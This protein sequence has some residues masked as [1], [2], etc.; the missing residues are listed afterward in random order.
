MFRK[1]EAEFESR[2]PSRANTRWYTMARAS[3]WICQQYHEILASH[4]KKPFVDADTVGVFPS[5]KWF[6][7]LFAIFDITRTCYEFGTKRLQGSRL[8][9]S[10]QQQIFNSVVGRLQKNISPSPILTMQISIGTIY[11]REFDAGTFIGKV[12]K[13]RTNGLF[14]IRYPDGL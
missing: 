4:Q 5:N 2:A 14:Q 9:L 10:Q 7:I 13:D 1:R 12:V 8:L 3:K 11:G 6:V